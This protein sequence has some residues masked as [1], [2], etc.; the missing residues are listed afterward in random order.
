MTHE[1]EREEV[2]AYGREM[3]DRN[4]TIHTSGNV[5]RRVEEGV[6]IT[7]SN[8]PYHDIRPEDVLLMDLEGKILQGD[9]N[10]SVEHKVHLA[11][12]RFREEIQGVIHSHPQMGTAFAAAR[13]P[14]PSFLDEFGV[15]VGEEVRV[16]DY[17]MSGTP[18][19]AENVVKAMGEDSNAVFL[20]SHGLVSVGRTLFD[21]MRVARMVE[22]AAGTYLWTKVLGGAAE[23]PDDVK[24]FFRQAFQIFRAG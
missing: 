20:A 10:P 12:Y 3:E 7:P 22:R 15:F 13:V 2:C 8:T 1:E 14:L 16:A 11:C 24:A 19:I 9:R 5:S 23:L 4:L 18:D 17:A 6:L 21:A